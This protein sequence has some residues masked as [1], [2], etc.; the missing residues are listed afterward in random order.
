MFTYLIS[1]PPVD[2]VHLGFLSF[3]ARLVFQPSLRDPPPGG[4]AEFRS[5]GAFRESGFVRGLQLR[6][7]RSHTP[8]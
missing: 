2:K 6:L 5:G 7:Q 8:S 3:T 4:S 1:P